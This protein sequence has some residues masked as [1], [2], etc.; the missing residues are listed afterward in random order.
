MKVDL[1]VPPLD[2]VTAFFS[3][4]NEVNFP[5]EGPVK[6]LDL[7]IN[8]QTDQ[9]ITQKN[10]DVFLTQAGLASENLA[11]VEQ[12]HGSEVLYATKA[13]RLGQ[14]D[15]LVT[16]IPG[17]ILGILVADCAVVLLADT[18]NKVIGAFH[19]GWRGAAGVIVP[20]GIE[21]MKS[22]GA[23]RL[24]AWIS[25]CI[26]PVSFEVGEE[27]AN[28]FPS[29]FVIDATFAK[30]HVDLQGFLMHQM[31]SNGV[32]RSDI[33]VD[34]RCTYSDD[35]FYSFRRQRTLSGRMLGVISIPDSNDK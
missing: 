14:A 21:M 25:P 22:L 15:G 8:T 20:K 11:Y 4:S 33:D 10:R 35:R 30:P 17:L 6:G 2:E 9:H 1:I 13:G 5:N 32:R 18:Q 24:K 26:G 7:G 12:I 16:D 19:A 31:V 29:A 27:V 28:Q 3:M 23:N 34:G